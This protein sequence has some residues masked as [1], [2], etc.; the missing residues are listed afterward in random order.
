V[1]VS[2]STSEAVYVPRIWSR[3]GSFAR[4]SLATL[5]MRFGAR[6]L[7]LPTALILARTLGPARYGAY[8]YGLGWAVLLGLVAVVG[9]DRF[10]VRTVARYT[11]LDDPARVRGVVRWGA[12]A[13]TLTSLAF[14]GLFAAV[15]P[16]FVKSSFLPATWICLALVPL[17]A[18]TAIRQAVMQGLGRVEL[19]FV[20]DQIVF[21]A[22]LL[23]LVAVAAGTHLVDLD[24]RW[25]AAL[26]ISASAL[27]FLLGVV[28]VRRSL[29]GTTAAAPPLQEP[30]EWMR[31][32]APFALIGFVTLAQVQAGVLILGSLGRA[33][34]TGVYQVA[35][36][37][38]EV[39]SLALVAINAPLAPRVARL[40]ALGDRRGLAGLARGTARA[41]FAVCLPLAVL[42]L[43]FRG[44]LLHLFGSGYGAGSTALVFLVAAQAFSAFTGP[45]GVVLMM[46]GGERIAAAGF[47]VGL[48]V[49]VGSGIPLAS[50]YGTTGAAVAQCLGVVAWNLVLWAVVRRRLGIDASVLGMRAA[51]G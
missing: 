17:F 30:R 35:A 12:Q 40:H 26:N 38:A 36:R 24:A 50:A 14:A 51:D 3:R 45:V 23:V 19:S 41:G 1:G 43:A 13:A 37:V 11:A 28:L 6:L 47:A 31:S 2:A 34:D 39:A 44:P 7:A 46:S 49:G 29:A 22:A 25:A 27:A 4:A 20:P 10:L 33:T 18:L 42:A 9:L 8:A 16:L 15:A 5:T 32:L 48:V 21:P